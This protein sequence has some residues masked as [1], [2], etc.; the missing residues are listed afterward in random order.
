VGSKNS[1]ASKFSELFRDNTNF[2]NTIRIMQENLKPYMENSGN[3]KGTKITN[4]LTALYFLRNSYGYYKK[5]C[6]V[7]HPFSLFFERN[8]F[9]EPTLILY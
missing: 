3:P 4:D 8:E 5:I 1:F 6:L 9:L 7:T 2:L